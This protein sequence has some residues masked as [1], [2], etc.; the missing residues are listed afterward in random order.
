[1]MFNSSSTWVFGN[2]KFN[3]LILMPKVPSICSIDKF[4]LT[5][6]DNFLSKVIKKILVDRLAQIIGW[7][8]GIIN[9]VLSF[10]DKFKIEL[11]WLQIV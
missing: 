3:F 7:V 4:R 10:A 5:I 9:L 8:F 1:M 6:L 11:Q 2:F